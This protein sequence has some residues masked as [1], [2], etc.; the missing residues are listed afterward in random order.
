MAA[1]TRAAEIQALE[2]EAARSLHSGN[3]EAAA[4]SW[5]RILELDSGHLRAMSALG[6]LAFRRGDMA[7]ARTAFERIVEADGSDPRPCVQLALACRNLGDEAGEEAAIR[8]ALIADPM[9]LLAL[10]LRGNLLERRGERQQAARAYAAMTAV[11]PPAERLHP[12]LRPALA[13]ATAYRDRYEHEFAAYLEERLAPEWPRH[14]NEDL[15]RF[16]DAIDIMVGRKRRYD[17]V[18]ALFHY[19][20]LP[21]I[22]FFDRAMFPWLEAVEAATP[23]IHDEFLDVLRSDEGFTPYISYPPDV[24]HNQWAELNNSPRWSAFHLYRNGQR[25]AANAMRCPCTMEALAGVAQPVL[26]GRT[27]AAMFSLL[28]PRTRIPPHNGVTNVRL[29]AHLPLIVPEGCGFRVGNDTRQWVPGKA[30][31][32]DDTI[33][34][35]AWNDSDRPRVVL[36][37]DIWHPHLGAAERAMITAFA[38][39]WLEFAGA[40]DEAPQ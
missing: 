39:C 38:H 11:A 32:F 31:V 25:E 40:A 6:Q 9:D 26:A 1:T 18:S 36:I 17:S 15:R 24:P 27:P 28:K 14:G 33:E 35:E 19:P 16:R 7:G 8:K 37:F 2:A 30:W 4:R 29:V 12:D 5:H 20:R 34:H 21:A 13:Q 22:E 23:A 10:F 3:D